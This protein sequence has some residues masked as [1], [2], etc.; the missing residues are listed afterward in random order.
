[1]APSAAAPYLSAVFVCSGVGCIGSGYISS[2]LVK[3]GWSINRARKTVMWTLTLVMSPTLLIA[4]RLG[5]ISAIMALICVAVGAHQALSTHLY[6][7][8]SDLFPSR[9]TGM[10]VGLGSCLI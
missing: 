6:T 2:N 9:V 7:L 1:M 3:R 10:V 4:D 8:A 5:N